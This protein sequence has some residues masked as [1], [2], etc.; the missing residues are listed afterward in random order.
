MVVVVKRQVLDGAMLWF[1]CPGCD[2]AHA[3][4]IESSIPEKNWKWNGSFDRPTIEPSIKATWE[5][6]EERVKHCCHSVITDGKITFVDDCT[7]S[8]KNTTVSL[9]EVTNFP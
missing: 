3:I 1:L 9:P 7:H 4:T 8:L 2:R 5:F 6:G